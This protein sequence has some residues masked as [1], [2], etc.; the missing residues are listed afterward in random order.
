MRTNII[1]D[2]DLVEE[3]LKYAK[4]KSKSGLI[5]MALQEFLENHQKLDLREL[6]GKIEFSPDYD[7]KKA[8][9]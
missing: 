4:T 1:L 2:D 7:Y 8:R 9:N 3:G 5:R 6:R